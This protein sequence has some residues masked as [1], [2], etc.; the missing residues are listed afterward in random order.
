MTGRHGFPKRR[1]KTAPAV[2]C[3]I[4]FK[5][6]DLHYLTQL[7]IL[8]DGFFECQYQRFD[9]KELEEQL[10]SGRLT[11]SPPDG[12]RI[13][14]SWL[15]EA[16]LQEG[17]FPTQIDEFLKEADDIVRELNG[18]P[19]TSDLCWRALKS[20][21]GDPNPQNLEALR[22]AYEAVPTQLRPFLGDMD[23]KDSPIRRHLYRPS[24]E[25]HER[26]EADLAPYRR[27]ATDL[28][29]V[30]FDLALFG[31]LEGRHRLQETFFGGEETGHFL[32]LGGWASATEATCDD[33]RLDTYVKGNQ[34]LLVETIAL[35]GVTAG[36]RNLLASLS[37][38]LVAEG[39]DEGRWLNLRGPKTLS[40][41]LRRHREQLR[42]TDG[43]VPPL[44]PE[45]MRSLLGWQLELEDQW[46]EEARRSRD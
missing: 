9:R 3:P 2:E 4:F 18:E 6:G 45:P 33:V 16:T 23:A 28:G 19:T 1:D 12:A 39:E 11:L 8:A 7:W 44:D 14:I 5:N 10:A 36:A 34:L 21:Q 25:V 37:R 30:S 32:T 41:L 17:R 38:K 42:A 20:F 15:G 46:R 27:A 31:E 22:L 43:I 13:S 24:K 35:P 40:G 29:F 26:W